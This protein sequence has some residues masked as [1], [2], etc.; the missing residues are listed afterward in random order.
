[1]KVAILFSTLIVAQA[2]TFGLGGA[3]FVKMQQMQVQFGILQQAH[4]NYVNAFSTAAAFPG[5]VNAQVQHCLTTWRAALV[6]QTM[7]YAGFF[8]D[9]PSLAAPPE[10][11]NHPTIATPSPSSSPVSRDE[12]DGGGEPV[13]EQPKKRKKSGR[14]NKADQLEHDGLMHQFLI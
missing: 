1:M 7:N 11:S 5:A 8:M 3:F 6:R 10:T 2:M 13:C 9:P 14:K 12:T 4:N